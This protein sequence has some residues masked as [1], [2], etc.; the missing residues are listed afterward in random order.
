MRI[1]VAVLCILLPTSVAFAKPK[2]WKTAKVIEA[3]TTQTGTAALVLPS[4]GGGAVGAATP[5]H[6]T[7]Y[8]LETDE[9]LYLVPDR[10]KGAFNGGCVRRL[11]GQ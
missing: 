2:E 1:P 9:F 3:Q 11:A 8:W 4:A 7:A 6:R 5:I 10:S